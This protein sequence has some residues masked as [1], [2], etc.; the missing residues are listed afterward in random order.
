MFIAL[1]EQR[2]RSYTVS[3]GKKTENEMKLND[4]IVVFIFFGKLFWFYYNYSKFC[5]ACFVFG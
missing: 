4:E 2:K 3:T 1:W 5:V